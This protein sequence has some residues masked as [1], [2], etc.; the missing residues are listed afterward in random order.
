VSPPSTWPAS[1]WIRPS[2]WRA[3]RRKAD[4]Y[5]YKA[6]PAKIA[7]GLWYSWAISASA[8]AG[9]ILEPVRYGTSGVPLLSE[10]DDAAGGDMDS[11]PGA[12][13]GLI[14]LHIALSQP[15]TPNKGLC[16]R[17]PRRKT[18]IEVNLTR[19]NSRQKFLQL[20]A[21]I[22]YIKTTNNRTRHFV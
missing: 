12:A 15:R 3:K 19:K 2:S 5:R 11:G 17:G 6:K 16:R 22:R 4:D 9:S 1:C 10:K 8:K 21:A 13:D 18:D 7:P 14:M 20:E